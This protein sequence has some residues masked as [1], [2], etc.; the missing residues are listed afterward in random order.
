MLA[1]WQA[2]IEATF[3]LP[4]GTEQ[5]RQNIKKGSWVDMRTGRDDS[6]NIIKAKPHSIWG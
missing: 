3:S 4:S 2:P 5:Q 1:G 6:A